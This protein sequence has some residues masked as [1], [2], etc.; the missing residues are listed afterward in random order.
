MLNSAAVSLQRVKSAELVAGLIW[1][2]IC[3]GD[4]R[5]QDLVKPG[6]RGWLCRGGIELHGLEQV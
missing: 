6:E 5:H 4:A 2:L 1:I 3:S